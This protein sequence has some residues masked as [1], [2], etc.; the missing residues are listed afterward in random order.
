VGAKSKKNLGIHFGLVVAELL[1]IAGFVVE[2]SRA[3]S[4]NTLSWAYVFEWPI[5]GAY[6]VY[7]WRKLLL[8]ERGVTP[9][10]QASKKEDTDAYNSYNEYLRSVHRPTPAAETRADASPRARP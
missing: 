10:R 1:C 7:M 2:L 9:E 8:E 6:A 5:F 4:G 3:R